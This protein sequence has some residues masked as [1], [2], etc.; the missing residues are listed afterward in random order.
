MK[1]EAIRALN[2]L[3]ID[4]APR[5]HRLMLIRKVVSDNRDDANRSEVTRRQREVR[6]RTAQAVVH[7]TMRCFDAVERDRSYNQNCH[8]LLVKSEKTSICN[9]I[10]QKSRRQKFT[11][12]THCKYLSRRIPSF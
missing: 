5:H 9:L 6:S 4:A 11:C 10:R 12:P 2:T 3:G 8:N 7:L 1:A